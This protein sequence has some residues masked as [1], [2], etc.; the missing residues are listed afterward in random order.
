MTEL[1][2][3][4]IQ[5]RQHRKQRGLSQLELAHA[6]SSTP[7]H[8]SFIETGRSRPGRAVILRLSDALN[9]TL[10]DSNELMLSAGLPVAYS[11]ISLDDEDMK[12]V[13]RIL[14]HVLKKHD[15]YPAWVIAPGLRFLACNQAAE[16]VFP[17]LVGMEPMQLI[18]LWCGLSAQMGDDERAVIVFQ[19]LQ[20][21]R[22]EAFHHPHPVIPELLRRVEGYA[23][24]LAEPPDLS[25]S[26][27]MC[28]CLV[29]NGKQI[30]TLTT[31]M[32][33]DKAVDVTMA[34][35]RIELVFPADEAGERAFNGN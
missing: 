10:R 16:R 30:R 4:G 22:H 26:A 3:I 24:D 27:V 6:A 33:F 2:A 11:E 34:E 31:V 15:P 23:A 35:L 14:E 32:R 19:T 1:S 25:E 13:R 29:V 7:R 12:P 28:P 5:L 20:G 8:I 18:D 17:G 9:L 21:L